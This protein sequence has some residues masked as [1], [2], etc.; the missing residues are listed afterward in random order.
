MRISLSFYAEFDDS[1]GE[2]FAED[3]RMTWNDVSF[4]R[5]TSDP[6]GEIFWYVLTSV[7]C[8]VNTQTR[9]IDDVT[10]LAIA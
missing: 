2:P 9:S 10:A 6:Q 7:Q 5:E 3:L 1:N 4:R 8:L